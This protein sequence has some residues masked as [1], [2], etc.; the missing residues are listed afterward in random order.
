MDILIGMGVLAL[1]A[2][3]AYKKVPAFKAWVDSVLRKE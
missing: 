1:V 3:I 2:F